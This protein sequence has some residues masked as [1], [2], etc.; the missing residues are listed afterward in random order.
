MEIILLQDVERLGSKDDIVTVKDGYAR[1]YLIPQ[2]MA[3]MAI[4]MTR[5]IFC[6]PKNST[7]SCGFK[8]YIMLRQP[9]PLTLVIK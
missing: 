8:S 5:V 4:I 7:D 1:N 9:K 6:S 3:I 2:K